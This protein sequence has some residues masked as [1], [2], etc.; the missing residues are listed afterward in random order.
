MGI[1]PHK[2]SKK[3]LLAEAQKRRRRETRRGRELSPSQQLGA[4]ALLAVMIVAITLIAFAG[5]S[6]AGPQVLAGQVSRVRVTAQIPFTYT[7]EILTDRAQQRRE[8]QVNAVYRVEMDSFQAFEAEIEQLVLSL[9]EELQPRLDAAEPEEWPRIVREYNQQRPGVE[10]NWEDILTLVRQIEPD[11]RKALFEEALLDLKDILRDGVFQPEPSQPFLEPRDGLPERD[12]EMTLQAA[13]TGLGGDLNVSRALYRIVRRGVTPNMVFDAERHAEN[14]RRAAESVE[15]IKQRFEEGDVVI[16]AGEEISPMDIEALEAYRGALLQLEERPG[17]WNLTLVRRMLL[18]VFLMCG[19]GL[20]WQVAFAQR[21]TGRQLLMACLVVLVSVAVLRITQMIGELQVFHSDPIVVATLPYAAPV[22]L[23]AMLLALLAGRSSAVL[24]AIII[25]IIFGI[26]RGNSLT[27]VLIA[28]LG[29]FTA[30]YLCRGAR[31]R[32]QVVRAGLF[33]GGAMA[34]AAGLHGLMTD[35]GATVAG[36]QAIAGL[37]SG[38]LSGLLTIVLLPLFES[39]FKSPSDI[40]LLELTDFN[41]PL[42]RKLQLRAPGTYHHSMMVAN[43]AE[44]AALE[45]GANSTVCR[46]TC[47]FH[48]IGKMLKPEYFVENQHQGENPHDELS[49]SMS[50]LV[51][52]N[53]VKEGVKLAKE[54]RLP[55]VV[56]DVIEQHHGTSL[57]RFF[58]HRAA[59]RQKAAQR[60][61]ETAADDDAL[62]AIDEGAFRYD[63]PRPRFTESAIILLADAIEAASRAMKK[64][65]PQAIEELV[66]AIIAEKVTDRQLDDAPLTLR[67]IRIVRD[68]FCGTLGNMLHSRVAYP[69]KEPAATR[70]RAET[71]APMP[72]TNPDAVRAAES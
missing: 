10:A 33:T 42:L 7:S 70:H 66:D 11:E 61:S 51:I 35:V 41:H 31:L 46:V 3:Q 6:P 50:A 26:M 15:P 55:K 13:V 44:R 60:T 19:A 52:K 24:G 63:G 32:G 69:G 12:A 28:M 1:L 5:Q 37:A 29:S 68:S 38:V 36:Q 67:D 71:K 34:V 40:S 39:L 59:Q 2:K 47:L 56:I 22:S 9:N 62:P 65:N 30:I 20:A 57:I 17:G 43:L 45:I 16:E 23:G 4:V 8:Q 25:A 53:H 49:P 72:L 14:L 48:D 18:T 58:Y 27:L 54:A 64:V 21:C